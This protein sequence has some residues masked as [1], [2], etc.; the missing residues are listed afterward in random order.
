MIQFEPPNQLSHIHKC[1][2]PA[3]FAAGK[4]FKMLHLSAWQFNDMGPT[5]TPSENFPPSN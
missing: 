5:K 4:F 1:Q 2:L 3:F